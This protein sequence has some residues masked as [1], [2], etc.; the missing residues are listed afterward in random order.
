MS[1]QHTAVYQTE[2]ITGA[3]EFARVKILY[4]FFVQQTSISAM[5]CWALGL[6]RNKMLR[7]KMGKGGRKKNKINKIWTEREREKNTT[8]WLA[9]SAH[10]LTCYFIYLI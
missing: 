4:S 6:Q 1:G 3:L 10:F 2:I 9:F 5:L 8:M 7:E